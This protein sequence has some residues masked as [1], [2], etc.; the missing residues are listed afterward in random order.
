MT[1]EE[2]QTVKMWVNGILT[3]DTSRQQETMN[4]TI[5]QLHKGGG[6]NK[7]SDQRPVVLLNSVYQL[8]NYVINERLEKIV[9]PANILEPGQDGGRQGRCIGINTQKVHFIQHEARRQ[10][11]RVYRVDIDSKTTFNAMSQAAL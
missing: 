6:T 2:V 10:G 7:T 11:K 1:D 3:E 8:L 5:L 9:E 4:G